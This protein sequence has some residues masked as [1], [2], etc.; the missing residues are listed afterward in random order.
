M[1]NTLP[2]DY[3]F[4]LPYSPETLFR[5]GIDKDGGYIIDRKIFEKTNILL[6]FG[7]ADEYSFEIDFLNKDKKNKVYIFD[8]SISHTFYIKEIFKNLRRIFKFKR[9]YENLKHILKIYSN[10]RKFINKNRVMFF[11]K[12]VTNRI[13]S[14]EDIK[15]SEIFKKI[16]LESND[17]ITLKIDIEGDEYNIIDDVLLYQKN[18]AQIVMEYHDT[19]QRKDL[20]FDN[21][22]KIQEFY[23]VV[24]IHGNNYRKFN[25][26]G[27][28]IN[29]EITFC[30]KKYINETC[31]K[32]YSFPISKLDFPNNPEFPDLKIEF[33]K[34]K[35]I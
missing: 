28:P 19:H 35:V 5:L 14:S 11:S 18:I 7:M 22:K 16:N 1:K 24:H 10:F 8:Y 12:K 15:V 17:E 26:D 31:K 3:N 9:R 6:S 21:V 25:N 32:S 27:F 23:S 4:I 34:E 30:K 29:I 2:S 20:F 13:K 33:Q